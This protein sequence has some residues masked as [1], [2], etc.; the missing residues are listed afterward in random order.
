M[1]PISFARGVPAPEC[2]AVDEIAD[3]AR[4]AIAADGAAVLSYGPGGGYPPL[5]RWLAERHGV[6]PN[7]VVVTS[8][9]LQGFVFLCEQLVRP[10]ARVLVEAPTYDRPIKILRRLGAEIVGVPMD[11][12]GLRVDALEEALD[13]GEPPAFLYTI[14]T[15]QN[16][17]GRTLSAERRAQVADLARERGLLVLEDDPYGLV[18]YEGE[19]PKTIFELEGGT[20]VAYASSFSKTIAPGVRVGYFVLPAELAARIEALAVS[21][22]ISP[23]FLT[24]ATVHEFIRRG[25]FEPNLARVNG[26]LKARRDAMLAALEDHMPEGASWSR[27]EGGYFIWLD[28]PEEAPA[29][30]QAEAAGVTFVPGTDFFADGSGTQ[31]MRLAFSYVSPAE[32]ADGVERLAGLLRHAPA[33]ASTL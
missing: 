9:S 2:L 22:Y 3:C 27:P 5:R 13:A 30:E 4:A 23:P 16:P 12:D 11:D 10:G 24:Q 29:L 8:G 28:L 21:T 15:F 32:I 26:L 17:S 6:E 19:A 33:P 1:A 20:N 7:R 14:A 18:R 25:N 31:S